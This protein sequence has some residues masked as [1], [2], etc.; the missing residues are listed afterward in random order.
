MFWSDWL[1]REEMT[2]AKIVKANM[3]GSYAEIWV[4]RFLQ[5]PNGVT[6]DVASNKVFWCDAFHDRIASVDI[7]DPTKIVSSSV[8]TMTPPTLFTPHPLRSPC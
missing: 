8:Q 3:D 2:N 5:W 1:P 4:S 7:D 6:A